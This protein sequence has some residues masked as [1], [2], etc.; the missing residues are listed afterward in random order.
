[1][2][3]FDW[4]TIAIF[5]LLGLIFIRLEFRPYAALLLAIVST[6]VGLMGL[7][8][9]TAYRDHSQLVKEGIVQAKGNDLR[10]LRRAMSAFAQEHEF[11]WFDARSF[12]SRE[13]VGAGHAY[14][15]SYR[16][17]RRLFTLGSQSYDLE[18]DFR[19][20]LDASKPI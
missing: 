10:E 12:V 18:V 5:V 8:A 14:I 9:G 3:G 11:D 16:R 2:F 1:M 6:P 7:E 19:T 15:L 13:K 20:P 17:T 4:I